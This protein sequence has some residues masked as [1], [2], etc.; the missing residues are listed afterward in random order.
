MSSRKH[1]YYELLG[2]SRSAD[3]E[4]IK[5][6]YR[7]AALAH[8]PDRNPGDKKAEDKFKEATEAYQ[9][10]SDAR[11]RQVYDQY[12]HEGL[13]AQ[14]GMGSGFSAAGFEDV[15]EG[16]FED[17]F[18]GGGSGRGRSRAAQGSDLQYDFEISFKEA[19]FG[20]EK[21]I[22]LK[23]EETCGTCRGDGAKPGTSV[24]TCST[25]RGSGKILS[26]SGF[27]SIS[28]TCN[29]CGGEG[30]SIEQACSACRGSGRVVADRKIQL[31]I[32]AGVNTGLRLRMTG[33]GEAGFRGGPRGDLYVD[34]HVKSHEFFKRDGN[35][36]SC[37]VPISFAQAALGDEIQIPTLTGSHAL[38]IPAGTQT[39]KLFR[40]KGKGV[41]SLRGDGI[42]D[43]EVIVIVETPAHLSDKQ[44]EL[45]RE[46]ASLAGEKAN[47][48]TA[49]FMEKAKKLFSM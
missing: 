10:L 15:F 6:A 12:G 20:A 16:I 27:F 32:P 5:K 41:S 8:H 2:V 23:R 44:K 39:G 19:V 33:E 22:D 4:E 14:G 1:D 21:S 38:K 9:V 7:K 49:S 31:K 34:I 18:G 48:I 37:E 30:V 26:S 3:A 46:F 11:K 43:Q 40:L 36:I 35:N 13:N 47:P 24:K 42:G 25:C 29:R 45:L 28:R 17:F